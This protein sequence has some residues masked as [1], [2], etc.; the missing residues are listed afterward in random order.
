MYLNIRSHPFFVFALWNH[1]RSTLGCP[2]NKNLSGRDVQLFGDSFDGAIV[3]K[4]G[5]L[6]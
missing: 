1:D 3:Q 6:S 2:A 4:E 5:A